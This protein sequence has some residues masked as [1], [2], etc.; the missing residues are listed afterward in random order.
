MNLFTRLNFSFC[1]ILLVC[2]AS[3]AQSYPALPANNLQIAEKNYNLKFRWMADSINKRLEPHAAL[4]LPV[5]LP[6]CSKVFYM[7]FDTGSPFTLFYKGK[8]KAIQQKYPEILTLN[9][10]AVI[11]QS[12]QFYVGAMPLGAK[13]IPI[14]ENG[15]N[16]INWK[17][18]KAI[19]II[20]TIGVDFFENRVIAINYPAKQFFN[21]TAIPTKLSTEMVMNDFMFV[22]RSILFPA[23]IKGKK[24]ILFFDSGS[25][26]FTLLTNKET[27]ELLAVPDAVAVVS[28]TKSWNRTMTAYTIPTTDIIGI[29]GKKLPLLSTTYMEGVSENQLAQMMRLGIGGLTGNQLFV[30]SVLII[31]AKNKKFGLRSK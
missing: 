23:S 27:A 29:A 2:N 15:S 16:E 21:G 5:K 30:N 20:G 24:S 25:S 6:G 13:Q 26:A 7:Q 11:L 1:I 12:N 14:K 18:K 8:M 10:S 9:D 17:N 31:D 28:K 3:L 4:L 22:R 19:E